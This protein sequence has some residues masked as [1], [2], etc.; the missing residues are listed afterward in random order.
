MFRPGSNRE[1]VFPNYRGQPTSQHHLVKIFRRCDTLIEALSF[2][3]RLSRPCAVVPMAETASL[4]ELTQLGKTLIE[5]VRA[6][7]EWS[8]QHQGQIDTAQSA[9][10]EKVQYNRRNIGLIH[11][12]G[13]R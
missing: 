4:V 1:P 5:P 13:V 7:A 12:A 11:L 3:V 10:D 2:L 8:R 6:L 9:F